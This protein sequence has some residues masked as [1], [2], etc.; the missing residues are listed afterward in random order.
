M[1]KAQEEGAHNP[2]SDSS[3][4]NPGRY[5]EVSEVIRVAQE[6]GVSRNVLPLRST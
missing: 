5:R 2:G 6:I 3:D 4:S 1:L